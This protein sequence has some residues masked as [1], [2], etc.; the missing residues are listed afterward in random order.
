M[1]EKN[2]YNPLIIRETN[3]LQK[4]TL[5]KTTRMLEILSRNCVNFEK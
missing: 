3:G 5:K 2:I 1:V 4:K